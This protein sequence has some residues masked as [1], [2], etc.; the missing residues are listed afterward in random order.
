L[1]DKK[2]KVLKNID[3]TKLGIYLSDAEPQQNFLYDKVVYDSNIEK[4][5][6]LDDPQEINNNKITVFAK[7]PKINI[8]I[9]MGGTYNPDFA[10]LLE[11]KDG[12]ML[13]LIVETKGYKYQQDIAGSEQNK[14][15][16]AKKFFAKL[17]QELPSIEIKY[18]TRLNGQTLA[19]VL[20]S[21]EK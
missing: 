10:Y 2:G 3:Y 12:K 9:P 4:D 1:Q 7:L 21:N 5:S 16:Y 8:P 19:E 17:Q 20:S 6:I 15:N 13:F 18:H 11:K 14:I